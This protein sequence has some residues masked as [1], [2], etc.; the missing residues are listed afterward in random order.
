MKLTSCFGCEASAVVYDSRKAGEGSLFVCLRGAATDGHRFAQ[1]AYD[2]G[3]RD[4]AV[5]YLLSLPEDARQYRFD[6]T[7]AALA[8][9]SAEFYGYPS[10]RLHLIGVTGTKGKTSTAFYLRAILNQAG[11]RC[12]MIGTLGV[13]YGEGEAKE[14]T[15][16]STPESCELHRI[17]ADMV[18]DGCEYCVMEVSSQAYKCGRVRGL[19]FDCGIFTNLS[20]D[21]IGPAEH[22]SYE[23]YRA[24]KAELFAH[25]RLSILNADDEACDFMRRAAAGTVVDY[26]QKAAAYYRSRN[27][28]PWRDETGMGS[29]FACIGGHFRLPS[30]GEYSVYNALAATAAAREIGVTWRDIAKAFES[31]VVPGRFEIVPAKEGVMAV[32]DY[33]HNELSLRSI[34]TALRPYTEGRLIVVFGSVGGKAEIRREGLG[35]A[36][37][38]LADYAVIT[39]DNPDFE[40]PEAIMADIEKGIG[41]APH[42]CIA[43]REKA[44]AFAL[45]LAKSGDTLLFAGKGHEDY[46][47]VKGQHIPFCEKELIAKYSAAASAAGA[48]V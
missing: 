25:S 10:E 33:A 1:A 39:S 36:A 3:C 20:P 48:L 31:A 5:E 42:T 23:D 47:I 29:A 26:S 30:P 11:R 17:F 45:E 2:N 14:A 13:F 34:L 40:S 4:F 27:L 43:D 22:E 12:G 15:V 28:K 44:I 24:C 9:I 32:I 41:D 46:Q 18:N 7:R 8:D 38:E 35:R 6:D 19:H 16:N 21:H 37:A